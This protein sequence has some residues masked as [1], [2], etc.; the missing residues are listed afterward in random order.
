MN[1]NPPTPETPE[2]AGVVTTTDPAEEQAVAGSN[3][4]IKT[5][6]DWMKAEENRPETEK[7]R[8][9]RERRERSIKVIGAVTDGLSAL[10]NLFFTTQ[11]A[12]NMYN[13]EKGSMVNASNERLERLKAERE[14]K[15]DEYLNFALK[16]GDVENERARTLCDLEA[17]QEARKLAREKAERDAELHKW[18][19]ALQP[20]KQRE[21]KGKADKAEQDAIA[22]QYEAQFAPQLQEAKLDT[23]RARA[24]A[25]RA[26]AANSYASASAHNRS[27]PNE[28]SAW[29][30]HGNEHKFKTED[31]AIAY[32]KQHGTYQ[33]T[34]EEETSTTKGKSAGR[35]TDT[36]TTK[37]KK[38]GHAA[39]PQKKESPTAGGEAGKKSPTS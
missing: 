38:T 30:E 11:Y 21:Q 35:A 24:G 8:K 34:E 31:A 9:K 22:A 27:N 3:R 20:D 4:Q 39:R 19:E 15:R 5:I 23:E 26:S 2:V 25:Q 36:T 29:D 17:K 32:A 13:H 12:P 10:S 16:L 28:F 7:E 18:Q 33:E 6:E 1:E 37:K 14:K